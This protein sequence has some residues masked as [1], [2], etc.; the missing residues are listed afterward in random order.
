MEIGMNYRRYV[1]YSFILVIIIVLFLL[2]NVDRFYFRLDLSRDQAF[3]ISSY[4][5]SILRTLPDDV[6]LTYYLSPRLQTRIPAVEE[7]SDILYE[8]QRISR[9]A[10]R[11]EII[12]PDSNP[13]VSAEE[14]GITPRELQVVENNEQTFALVYSGM[15]I[16]YRDSLEVIPIIVN[17]VNLEYEIT[18]RLLSLTQEREQSIAILLAKADSEPQRFQTMTQYLG[19]YYD[20]SLLQAGDAIPPTATA[21]VVLGMSQLDEGDLYAIEQFILSGKGVFIATEAAEVN[22]NQGLEAVDQGDHPLLEML[23]HYGIQLGRSWVLDE[24]NLLI[25][26]QQQQG[27]VLINTYQTYPQ[28]VQVLESEANSNHPLSVRFQGLDLFWASPITLSDDLKASEVLFS[29]SPNS[30]LGDSFLTDPSAIQM[31]QAQDTEGNYALAVSVNDGLSAWFTEP[32][33]QLLERGI[34][35]AD[36]VTRSDKTRLLVFGDSDFPSELYQTGGSSYNI[37]LTQSIFEYLSGDEELLEI[38]TRG[39]RNTRLDALSGTSMNTVLTLARIFCFGILP[40]LIAVFAIIRHSQRRKKA[41]IPFIS[42][43][44][45]KNE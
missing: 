35:Y 26:V 21:L 20:L 37:L 38:R 13:L 19:Q 28:W 44:D 18:S 24:H 12:D 25:P 4:S 45:S 43:E 40:A 15:A 10:F 33:E 29:S 5:K 36:P 7:I 31:R 27:R 32:P 23:A 42:S 22:L 2:L 14:L 34:N 17:S 8:Y 6:E 3:S 30:I 39:S 11:V 9:G 16:S 1:Q 41:K